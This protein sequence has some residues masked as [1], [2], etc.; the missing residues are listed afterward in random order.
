[1]NDMINIPGE[2]ILARDEHTCMMCGTQQGEQW[3]TDPSRKKRMQ[4]GSRFLAI[5]ASDLDPV[6]LCTLCDECDEGLQEARLRNYSPEPNEAVQLMNTIG[7]TRQSDQIKVLDWLVNK[8]PNE[9][10]TFLK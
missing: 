9:A 4:V 1:M 8:F 6:D 3:E 10:K 5:A 2:A 7:K